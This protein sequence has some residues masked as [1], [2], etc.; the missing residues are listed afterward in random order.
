MAP[1]WDASW[2]QALDALELDLTDTEA[3]IERLHA[4][5]AWVPQP[6]PVWTAPAQPLPAPLADRASA[7]LERHRRAAEQLT[8]ALV[9]N[10]RQQRLA[11]QLDATT[12]STPSPFY[13]DAAV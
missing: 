6:R 12:Y 10:R 3:M 1:G 7:L 13:V 11:A 2:A 9:A 5:A 4:D 8:R